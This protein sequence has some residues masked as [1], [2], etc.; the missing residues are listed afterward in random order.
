MPNILTMDSKNEAYKYLEDAA[1]RGENVEI[2]IRSFTQL[3]KIVQSKLPNYI[4]ML[5]MQ[6]RN[7]R[8]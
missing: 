6:M 3:A 2:S 1:R 4:S 7:I 8:K 5:K